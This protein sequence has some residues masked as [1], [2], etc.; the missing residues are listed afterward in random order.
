MKRPVITSWH[1]R[2][3]GRGV[4]P[5]DGKHDRHEAAHGAAGRLSDDSAPREG[6]GH[7]NQNWQSLTRATGITDYLKSDG[8]LEHAQAM[9][10]HSS[11]RT[12]KLYDRR[13]DE[14]SL[15]E[16]EKVGI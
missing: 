2:R 14:A 1:R 7:Q 12:T 4:I 13:N 10:N 6:G 3:Q 16:Y 11:P 5:H 8:T 9:A 15:D